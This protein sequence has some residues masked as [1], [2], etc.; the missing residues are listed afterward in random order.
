MNFK[1]SVTRIAATVVVAFGLWLPHSASGQTNIIQIV[2]DDL[3][4]VDLSTG[5]TNSGNGSPYYQ[6]PNIDALAAAGMSFTSA[7]VQQSCAPTRAAL[8]AGQYAPRNRVYTVGRGLSNP[9]DSL[10]VVPGSD[11][12]VIQ[13]SAVTL[14]ETLRDAGYLTAH[15]GKFQTTGT[16]D[17]IVTQHGFQL[18]VGGTTS[19]GLNGRRHYFAQEAQPGVWEFGSNHGT[20]FNIYAD[21]YDADYIAANLLPYANGNDP[22]PLANTP[23]NLNDAMADAAVEFLQDRTD[24]GQKFFVNLAFNAVH[25]DINSR[26]DLE[27]KY[28]QLQTSVTPDHSNAAYAGLVEGLDQAVGRIVDF[29]KSSDLAGNT[30]IIFVSDNGGIRA[31]T[32][33]FPLSGFKGDFAEGGIR[34][35]LIAFQP[36]VVEAEQSA[37]KSY[38]RSISTRLTQRLRGPNYQTKATMHSMANRSRAF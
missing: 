17:E 26:E 25:V 30:L 6:T 14:A 7:Y 34:V 18:N 3:G 21:P 31:A 20:G 22:L 32:D 2:A 29:V 38:T 15:F 27:Q 12:D 36:G 23:K 9:N 8:F 11:D 24:D 10:L 5:A 4:W 35:P 37:T 33:N 28:T 13:N 16:P 1:Q 19:G